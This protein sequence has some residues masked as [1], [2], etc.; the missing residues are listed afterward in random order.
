MVRLQIQ[1]MIMREL[2]PLRRSVALP[3]T[4][5]ATR[6]FLRPFDRTDDARLVNLNDATSSIN[7]A[8][9]HG[10]LLICQVRQM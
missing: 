10:Q 5:D 2:A 6:Q 3:G 7:K 9:K 4:S 8:L 1:R